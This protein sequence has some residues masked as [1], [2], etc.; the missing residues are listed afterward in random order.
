MGNS[1]ILLFLLLSLISTVHSHDHHSTYIVHVSKSQ[2]PAIFMTHHHWYSSTLMTLPQSPHPTKILY[3]YDHAIH[4]FAARLT[5][6]QA[7]ALQDLPGI[8]SVQSERIH[9]LD[10]THT[11]KFLGLAD[12]SGIW[13]NSDYA[14]DIIIGV[15][16][17]GIWPE[18]RSFS[19]TGLSA[20]PASWKGSC[21][22]ATNFS[23]SAC[24][25][26][27]IGARA[28]YAG[29]EEYLQKKM[30]E[31]LE[32]RSP[33]DTEG[34]GTHTASTAAGSTVTSA[35]FY[36]LSIGEARGI[37]TKARI[38]VY[39]ICWLSGCFDSDILA[40]MDESIADGVHII[41]LSLSFNMPAGDYD[42]DSIAIGSFG[43]VQRGV[44]ISASAGNDG[45]TPGSVMNIAPWIFTVGAS[46]VDREF[47]AN[48]V[49]GD[50][51]TYSGVSLY[52]GEPFDSSDLSLV[53]GGSC[54][55][56]K[57]STVRGK[58]VVCNDDSDGLIIRKGDVV[59]RAGGVGMIAAD[60]YNE[61]PSAE[62]H[63]IPATNVGKT[64]GASIRKYIQSK[65]WPW[66]SPT[67]T[68]VFKRTVISNSP[69][70][71]KV[72]RF[73]SRGPTNKIPEILKP[74]VI[75]P[76]VNILASWTGFTSPTNLE[77][78]PRRVE[79]NIKSGT[80]MACPHVSGLG[81]L[82]RKA[83]PQWSPAA[84]KS[85]L[86]TTSY[87]VDSSG[88]NF[89]D[90]G[91]RNESTPFIH[92][93]GHVDPNKSLNPGLI[94]DIN[95]D[96][97]VAFLCAIGYGVDRIAVFIKDKAA[98]NCSAKSMASPGD[99]NYPSFSVVFKS[100]RDVVQRRRVVTNVGGAGSVYVANITGPST[101]Q[102]NVSPS[103][104]VFSAQNQSLSYVITF[105][106]IADP[107]AS[108][109]FGSITWIDGAHVVR[110]PI[111][112]C[113]SPSSVSSI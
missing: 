111:A 36:N 69:V 93:A 92:G 60:S 76:G 29:Y 99:L 13:P 37:A 98:V 80:S 14:N 101:V 73:S 28:Y 68:I 4:G 112:I 7:A 100:N 25:R 30:N 49:L 40:A 64:A 87:N 32:S 47:P 106:S 71:P 11:P 88:G 67:A 39:K 31:T 77:I 82:L 6:S 78:D 95:T 90:Q 96:D 83:H 65:W 50:G 108:M 5:P 102:I 109:G 104:L 51:T 55:K 97:Y 43:A 18:R 15:L 89:E 66:S 41:S 81:A 113:W 84:I 94:Y 79:F 58:I 103:K 23:T 54:L 46:T 9:H 17:S 42:N 56:L 91:T 34:H 20:V 53:D 19:D 38:A 74:D 3:T 63:L 59:K 27:L 72:A 21:E 61:V 70:S 105:A 12:V 107:T 35:G 52:S 57:S 24:N 8:L 75:A 110:S 10:T 1:S 16:D 62:L 44:L 45:P 48:V 26:K 33:R 22:T 86:M 2:K 85:A